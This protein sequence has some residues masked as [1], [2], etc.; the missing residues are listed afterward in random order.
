[1]RKS[2]SKT[3]EFI[4]TLWSQ[5]HAVGS[6][7]TV[8]AKDDS[9][10]EFCNSSFYNCSLDLRR[11]SGSAIEIKNQRGFALVF[12]LSILPIILAAGFFLLFSQYLTQNWM[13]SLHTCR[14]ELLNTQRKASQTLSQLM[15]LNKLVKTLRISLIAAEAE[16]VAALATEDYPLAAQA[17]REI[18]NIKKQQKNLA[19]VQKTLIAQADL[20]MLSGVAKLITQLRAQDA[21]IRA[22]LPSFFA[23]HI[24]KMEPSV[25]TLAVKPDSSDVAPV[26]EL[27]PSFESSQAL[28]VSWISV[29]QTK[30]QTNPSENSK[31]AVQWVH[32]KHQKKDF[33][34][35]SL[36]VDGSKYEAILRADKFL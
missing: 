27:K 6:N 15:E 35:A 28:S 33:C 5:R 2:V 29:F 18:L 34:S 4:F 22:R 20:Q 25:S 14:T 26:Y 19:A 9:Q 16:L 30:F 24:E 23:Y 1:M 7:R 8:Q 32:Q 21:V 12:L 17:E 11:S 13:Q 3:V 10:N 36:K 31:G